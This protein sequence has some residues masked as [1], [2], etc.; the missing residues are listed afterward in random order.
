VTASLFGHS[1]RRRQLG[2]WLAGAFI[3]LVLLFLF[4]PIVLIVLFSFNAS[5]TLSFPI[6]GLT[7]GWYREVLSDPL[8]VSALENSLKLA[9]LTAV[10][11]GAL[12]TA[13]AFGV[14][15]F[16]RRTQGAI[17]YFVLLPSILPVLVI[18]IAL[19]VF[20][21]ALGIDLSLKTAAIGHILIAFPFVFLILRARLESFDFSLLEAARDSGASQS[22]AFR[23]V[24]LPLIRPA[25]IG[26][27]L[28]S[29]SLSLDEFVITSF[30]IGA[31][32][33]LPVLIWAKLRVGLDPGVNA[34]ATL[35]LAGTLLAGLLS[36]R[37]SRI[38]L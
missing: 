25:I 23:D 32:Q 20:L 29:M 26:A 24:T 31:D 28:V 6:T 17:T 19:A 4:L 16:G 14:M 1:R 27:A 2:P 13:A 35:V 37:L 30:T 11:A 8:F 34:L 21:N 22:R 38:R 12:G 18:A 10:V 9:A 33:T 36:Y 7:F 5:P 15:R 3:A